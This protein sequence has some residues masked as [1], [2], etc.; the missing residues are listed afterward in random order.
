M[1]NRRPGNREKIKNAER[2]VSE[3]VKNRDGRILEERKWCVGL[4][5]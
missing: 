1:G 4:R 5:K 2:K 3:G